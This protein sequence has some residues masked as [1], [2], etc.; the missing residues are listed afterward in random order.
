MTLLLLALPAVGVR[1]ATQWILSAVVRLLRVP[2]DAVISAR[3]KPLTAS[4][5]VTFT[6]PFAVVLSVEALTE[7]E[8]VGRVVSIAKLFDVVVPTPAVPN[9]ALL[10]PVLSRTIVLVALVTLELGVKVAMKVMLSLVVSGPRVP[11]D[12]VRSAL[13]KPVTA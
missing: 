13:V 2:L 7:M 6:V 5:K 12:T 10:T 8:A 3:L 11:L 1:V 9:D 4:L